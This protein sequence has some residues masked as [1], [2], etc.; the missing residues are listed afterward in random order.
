VTEDEWRV[1]IDLDDEGKGYSLGERLRAHDLDDEAR[2]R[3]GRRVIVTRDGPRVFLYA[4][5]EEAAR[6]AERVARE[7]LEAER[8]TGSV[9]ISYWDAAAEEW[10]GPETTGAGA[11]H[12]YE[13]EVHVDLPGRNEARE[14]AA[15]LAVE[16]LPAHRLWRWV[17]VDART[18]DD[19]NAIADQLRDELPEGTEIRVEPN[20]EGIPGPAFVW[21]ETRV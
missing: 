3:L 19:A 14:L 9:R 11:A 17:T 10:R 18:S 4:S 5:S 16:G 21:L 6:E 7:L 2:E 12:P 13:W 20:P 1:E 15:R 8:L